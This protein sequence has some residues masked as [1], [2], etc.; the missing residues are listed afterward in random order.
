MQRNPPSSLNPTHRLRFLPGLIALALFLLLSYWGGLPAPEHLAQFGLGLASL[1]LCLAALGW[2]FWHLLLRPLPAGHAQPIV[3]PLSQTYRQALSLLTGISG[4]SIVVGGFW[5]E[6]WHRQYG[7]PFGEDFFWRPHIMMYSGFAIVS[8]LALGSLIWLM[9]QG[10]GTWQQ[11]FRANPVLSLLVFVGG[12]MIYALPVDPLWHAIYGEDITAWSVPHLVLLL[13][14]STIMLVAAAIYLTTTRTSTWVAWRR[15]TTADVLV[16]LNLTFALNITLQIFTTEWDA[17][18]ALPTVFDDAFW[19]RPEWL[20]P[21]A[22]GLSAAFF[23]V[24]AN[25]SLR[26]PGAATAVGVMGWAIRYGLVQLFGWPEISA[27]GWLCIL[28]AFLALD[29]WVAY[30]LASRRT[31]PSWLESG[32]AVWVGA[33]LGLPLIGRLFIY[34]PISWGNAPGMLVTMLVSAL[35]AA[36]A[37]ARLGN[38]LATANKATDSAESPA[39]VQFAPP[40]AFLVVVAL[41]ILFITTAQPPA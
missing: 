20:F 26:R 30:R 35:M 36:W 24:L 6:V 7:L 25:H 5:D 4:L 27:R 38:Y 22:L 37:G 15:I 16:A 14:F 39:W 11:R 34:P 28:P 33:S 2:L 10:K 41:M 9:R 18:R 29:V 3:A 31:A 12:F 32:L 40:A 1:V 23:G 21:A 19:Q 8:L 17:I 13:S